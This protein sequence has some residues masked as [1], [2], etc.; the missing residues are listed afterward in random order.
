MEGG[1]DVCLVAGD[2]EVDAMRL[3]DSF[4][5]SDRRLTPPRHASDYESLTVMEQ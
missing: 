5:S 4:R 2:F 1:G 3:W